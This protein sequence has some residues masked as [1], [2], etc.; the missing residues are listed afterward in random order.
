MARYFPQVFFSIL[1]GA[2]SLGQAG[3]SMEAIA[4][5]KGAAYQVFHIIDRVN[6]F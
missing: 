4:T 6:D 5:A 3:P 1:F 2:M